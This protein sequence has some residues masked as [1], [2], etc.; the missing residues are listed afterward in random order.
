MISLNKFLSWPH[1]IPPGSVANKLFEQTVCDSEMPLLWQ[2][3]TA[4][5]ELRAFSVVAVAQREILRD[6][7]QYLPIITLWLRGCEGDKTQAH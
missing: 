3:V 1:W 6:S 7:L 4:G 2:T 5:E